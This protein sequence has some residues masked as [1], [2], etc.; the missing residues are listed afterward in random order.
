MAD[1]SSHLSRIILTINKLIDATNKCLSCKRIASVTS[2]NIE[3]I[4]FGM[5]LYALN[6]VHIYNS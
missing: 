4:I 6:T 3:Q 1:T 2:R 5:P